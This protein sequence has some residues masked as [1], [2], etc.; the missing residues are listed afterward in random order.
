MFK[1]A[2][3]YPWYQAWCS[4]CVY[5]QDLQEFLDAV[6]DWR[7]QPLPPRNYDEGSIYKHMYFPTSSDLCHI[8]VK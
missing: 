4:A 2:N 8:L 3:N 7:K 6:L 5:H 1:Q